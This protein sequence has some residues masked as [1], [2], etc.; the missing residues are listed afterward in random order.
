MTALVVALVAA[1]LLVVIVVV[2]RRR[3]SPDTVA[4]FRRQI[5]ALSSEARR[6]VV[7]QVSQLERDDDPVA[8]PD[9]AGDEPAEHPDDPVDPLGDGP[10]CPEDEPDAR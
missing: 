6:P 5:D 3:R 7:D 10:D 2:V 9:D 4:S 1:V 8:G